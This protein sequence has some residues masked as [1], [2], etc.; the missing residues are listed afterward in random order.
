MR[1]TRL[2][3]ARSQEASRPCAPQCRSVAP[4][5]PRFTPTPLTLSVI[6]A[7]Q[8]AGALPGPSGTS[9]LTPSLRRPDP[10]R[11]PAA[12]RLALSCEKAPSCCLLPSGTSLCLSPPHHPSICTK[13]HFPDSVINPAAFAGDFVLCWKKTKNHCSGHDGGDGCNSWPWR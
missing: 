3:E 11:L 5:F 9:K 13:G 4:L 2:G 6:Q 12:P 1:G 8:S 10:P 7:R